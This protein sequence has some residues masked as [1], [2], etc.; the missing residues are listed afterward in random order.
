M[1]RFAAGEA[2]TA[3]KNPSDFIGAYCGI[4][5]TLEAKS[6][7]NHTSFNLVDNISEHQITMPQQ[8]AAAGFRSYFVINNRSTPRSY[9][10]H[11]YTVDTVDALR[12]E[13]GAADK[14]SIRWG[15]LERRAVARLDRLPLGRWDVS[16]FLTLLSG[17]G[18]QF[19]TAGAQIV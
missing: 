2:F 14:K 17:Q 18:R 6:S 3:Q 12:R 9:T 15:D 8:M 13:L 19:I 10:A 5:F 1:L 16:P 7:V 4:P 11:L